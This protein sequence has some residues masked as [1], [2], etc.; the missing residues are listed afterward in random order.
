MAD[1]FGAFERRI[2]GVSI[3]TISQLQLCIV[4]IHKQ[5]TGA[6]VLLCFG[7]SR[8]HFVRGPVHWP[9]LKKLQTL[10]FLQIPLK[11]APKDAYE[12]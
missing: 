6:C 11:L 7:L 2:P 1:L 9:L 8:R 5:P 12:P 4:L 10:D 3:P